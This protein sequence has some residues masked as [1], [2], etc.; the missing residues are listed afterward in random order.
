MSHGGGGRG[1]EPSLL[2]S[3]DIF[4]AWA[5]ELRF[6][7]GA[8]NELS[9]LVIVSFVPEVGRGGGGGGDGDV[10]DCCRW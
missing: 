7:G 10:Y 9:L 1:G 6:T 5:S 8:G 4:A 3:N 2:R